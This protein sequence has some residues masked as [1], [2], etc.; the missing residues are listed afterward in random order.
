MHSKKST[1]LT[2]DQNGSLIFVPLIKIGQIEKKIKYLYQSYQIVFR[3]IQL[4]FN[5]EN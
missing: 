3:K 4:I 5:T 2:T 1:T